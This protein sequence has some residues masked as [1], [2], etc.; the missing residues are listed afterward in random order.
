MNIKPVRLE[1][2]EL[3]CPR[4]GFN[5]LHHERVTVFD[6]PDDHP[7]TRVVRIDDEVNVTVA[8][9]YDCGNPS[10]RRDGLLIEFWCEEC[11]YNL[12]LQIAQHKGNTLL[13]W[14]VGEAT[15]NIQ[16]KLKQIFSSKGNPPH[17]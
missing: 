16:E 6:R 17:E 5:Y 15:E 10:D 8:T 1:E 12:T 4:C 13:S 3:L 14:R 9:S 2:N 11:G 7:T